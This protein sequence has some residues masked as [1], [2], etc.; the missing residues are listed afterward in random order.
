MQ[1]KNLV[2]CLNA[3]YLLAIAD[4]WDNAC[5][6]FYSVCSGVSGYQKGPLKK[7]AALEMSLQ[8]Y[9]IFVPTVID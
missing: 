8:E 2:K 9:Q 1:I 4:R 7:Y 5:L 6:V 3:K